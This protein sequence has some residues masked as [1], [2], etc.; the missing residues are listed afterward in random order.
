MKKQLLMI[1]FLVWSCFFS[2]IAFA[3]TSDETGMSAFSEDAFVENSFS[4]SPINN[5]INTGLIS[6][7]TT[8]FGQYDGVISIIRLAQEVLRRLVPLTIGLAVLAFFWFLVQFIWKGAEN[9]E[10]R[11]KSLSAMGWSI[12]ALF[13]MVSIWGIIAFM[14]KTVGIDQGGSINGFKLPGQR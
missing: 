10:V 1:I 14:G 8:S 12:L 2:S 9:P 7:N 11:R 3:Q 4:Q 6:F 5:S 13:V